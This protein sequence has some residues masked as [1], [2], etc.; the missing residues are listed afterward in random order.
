MAETLLIIMFCVIYLLHKKVDFIQC[1]VEA[2]IEATD[3]DEETLIT[4]LKEMSL[5]A[6]RGK[7]KREK[8]LT[9]EEN[10]VE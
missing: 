8:P 1:A 4:N 6:T 2:L 5:T 3:I 7:L 10:M 9:T